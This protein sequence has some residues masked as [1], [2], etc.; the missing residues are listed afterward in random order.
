VRIT[1]KGGFS[2]LLDEI[3]RIKAKADMNNVFKNTRTRKYYEKSVFRYFRLH[4]K[5]FK[6]A[7][8][9]SSEDN[10]IEIHFMALAKMKNAVV[11]TGDG[12]MH[13]R[14][15]DFGDSGLILKIDL[16][17]VVYELKADY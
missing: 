14:A 13:F 8:S 3:G 2:K 11:V 16:N 12:K 10:K 6:P 9:M 15:K 5:L 17:L 7:Q 4:K 1:I